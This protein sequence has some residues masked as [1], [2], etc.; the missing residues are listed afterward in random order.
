MKYFTLDNFVMNKKN[1]KNIKKLLHNKKM[2]DILI[3]VLNG[4]T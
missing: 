1:E 3:H 2:R 4:T